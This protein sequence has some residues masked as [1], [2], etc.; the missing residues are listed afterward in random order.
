MHPAPL[1]P[2]PRPRGH[3]T[4]FAAC[5]R[6][7]TDT[8]PAAPASASAH[9]GTEGAG[10]AALPA[11]LRQ[12]VLCH[13][14]QAC[15]S[16]NRGRSKAAGPRR[17]GSP[18]GLSAAVPEH[19]L[20]PWQ[21]C[22]GCG[23]PIPPVSQTDPSGP[24]SRPG[25]W[26]PPA[27]GL[28]TPQHARWQGP[29]AERQ[30]PAWTGWTPGASAAARPGR[31]RRLT[32]GGKRGRPHSAPRCEIR[33]KGPRARRSVRPALSSPD[34][35]GESRANGAHGPERHRARRGGRHV[36]PTASHEL[37]CCGPN[38]SP[39]GSHSLRTGHEV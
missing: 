5:R 4:R 17:A 22:V 14:G 32:Q 18:A 8:G 20:R 13:R 25:S 10:T 28:L 11:S 23:A 31:L 7:P 15:G 9:A 21:M 16:P 33:R 29:A 2:T 3:S 30:D 19:S 27:T 37:I 35:A 12:C 24:Q 26:G 39:S 38:T 1:E 6:A 34:G 36:D